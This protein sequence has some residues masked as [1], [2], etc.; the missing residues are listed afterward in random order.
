VVPLKTFPTLVSIYQTEGF[1]A[2]YRGYV[3]RLLRLG[4]G[5]GVMLVAF[6]YIITM[7]D[8]Y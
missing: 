3:A 8:K 1:R 4:P 2:L 7:L 5:G 6:D